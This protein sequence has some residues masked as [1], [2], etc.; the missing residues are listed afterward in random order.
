M[1]AAQ[2]LK[3]YDA[4]WGEYRG[5]SHLVRGKDGATSRESSRSK[6]VIVADLIQHCNEAH[7]LYAALE[8]EESYRAC[9]FARRAYLH[10]RGRHGEIYAGVD[11]V[12][13]DKFRRAG[14]VGVNP[15]VEHQ[16][17]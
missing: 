8:G 16:E 15:F 17:G 11:P 6:D 12:A 7:A 10:T 14:R 3:G 13:W 4:L 1:D 5:L 9:M 2:A